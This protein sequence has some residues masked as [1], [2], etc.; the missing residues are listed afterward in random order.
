MGVLWAN[1]R[2]RTSGLLRIL[3]LQPRHRCG[4]CL[5]RICTVETV[6]GNASK[7]VGCEDRFDERITGRLGEWII[8]Y[9]FTA[10][11]YVYTLSP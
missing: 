2:E 7:T 9:L 1:S 6:T 10:L 8:V 5:Y 3:P 4:C 11:W